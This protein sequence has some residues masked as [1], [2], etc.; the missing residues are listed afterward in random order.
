MSV[1]RDFRPE[2]APAAELGLGIASAADIDLVTADA[3]GE[4]YAEKIRK[5]LRAG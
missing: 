1:F 5:I 2:S 3:A 4:A